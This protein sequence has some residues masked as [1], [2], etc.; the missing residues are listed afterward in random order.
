[1]VKF[2]LEHAMV[3]EEKADQPDLTPTHAEGATDSRAVPLERGRVTQ[4]IIM[5]MQNNH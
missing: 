4:T 2:L 5:D 3:L 1:M